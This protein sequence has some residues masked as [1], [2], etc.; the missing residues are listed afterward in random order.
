MN[1][2]LAGQGPLERLVRPLATMLDCY[3][4]D[5]EMC[6]RYETKPHILTTWAVHV[7]RPKTGEQ[8]ELHRNRRQP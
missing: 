1:E 7:A 5:A 2:E 8:H 3:K 4:L 6:L